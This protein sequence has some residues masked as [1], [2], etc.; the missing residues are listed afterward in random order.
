MSFPTETCVFF[1][2]INDYDVYWKNRKETRKYT[3]NCVPV[4]EKPRWSTL[5]R[6]DTRPRVNSEKIYKE[7]SCCRNI[8]GNCNN[9]DCPDAANGWYV[10]CVGTCRVGEI[11]EGKKCYVWRT[12]TLDCSK[13]GLPCSDI[14]TSYCRDASDNSLCKRVYCNV[15]ETRD[16]YAGSEICFGNCDNPYVVKSTV[17]GD[18]SDRNTCTATHSTACRPRMI[19]DDYCG[20]WGGDQE[21]RLGYYAICP[22]NMEYKDFDEMGY[23]NCRDCN[24]CGEGNGGVKYIGTYNPSVFDKVGGIGTNKIIRSV[25]IVRIATKQVDTDGYVFN[26]FPNNLFKATIDMTMIDGLQT[27]S[28]LKALVT[29]S[30]PFKKANEYKFCKNY[31][32]VAMTMCYCYLYMRVP[33]G[34][35]FQTEVSNV[36]SWIIKTCPLF[37]YVTPTK[38]KAETDIFSVNSAS[39]RNTRYRNTTDFY[40]KKTAADD[41]LVLYTTRTFDPNVPKIGITTTPATYLVEPVIL[42]DTWNRTKYDATNVYEKID[43]EI[44]DNGVFMVIHDL[45]N[46]VDVA[47]YGRDRIDKFKETMLDVAIPA[48]YLVWNQY[49]YANWILPLFC[50]NKVGPGETSS[51]PTI[52]DYSAVDY[53]TSVSQVPRVRPNT[54]S[55]LQADSDCNKYLM[56]LPNTDQPVANRTRT[57]SNLDAWSLKFCTDNPT[58]LECQCLQRDRV[59]SPYYSYFTTSNGL[60]VQSRNAAGCWYTP[61]MGSGQ[62][63]IIVPSVFRSDRRQCSDICSNVISVTDTLRDVNL[64]TISLVNSCIVRTSAPVPPTSRP[65]EKPSSDMPYNTAMPDKKPVVSSKKDDDASP[66][67]IP[68]SPSSDR[69]IPKW[70]VILLLVIGSLL[71][72]G[73]GGIIA[74]RNLKVVKSPGP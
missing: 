65:V 41:G 27:M 61:C 26:N 47:R 4:M 56:R 8:C 44:S 7:N 2:N 28:I 24:S 30:E 74:Y 42:Y 49:V 13:N 64:D 73:G 35:S 45:T 5:I 20:V 19:A 9:K 53:S 71:I 70:A 14:Q 52:A 36:S 3:R 23:Y 68:D 59:G 1:K 58:L 46:I 17:T 57:D 18:S 34:L 54:C 38:N 33:I 48:K 67:V 69:G 62:N 55:Y 15:G 63:N 51:C 39:T 72:I 6:Y 22:S 43:P 16:E 60:Q 29:E 10:G 40:C 21:R 12:T 25:E 11:A 37:F 32:D 31:N 66:A 50:Y